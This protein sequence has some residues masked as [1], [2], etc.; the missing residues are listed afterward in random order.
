MKNMVSTSLLFFYAKLN[1]S[2]IYYIREEIEKLFKGV[3]FIWKRNIM[4]FMMEKN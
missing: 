3:V 2:N 1:I 4:A